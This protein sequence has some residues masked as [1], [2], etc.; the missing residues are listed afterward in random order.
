M[1]FWMVYRVNG[2]MPNKRHESL[3]EAM[4]EASRLASK[5]NAEIY[6]LEAVGFERPIAPPT[7]WTAF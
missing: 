5:E 1:K 4:K 6:V 2:H 7:E 3:V